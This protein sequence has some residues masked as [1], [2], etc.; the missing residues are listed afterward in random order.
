MQAQRLVGGADT[1]SLPSELTR[2][3]TTIKDLDERSGRAAASASGP[4]ASLVPVHLLQLALDE[5]GLAG[6][7]AGDHQ[8]Q[9]GA[10][11]AEAEPIHTQSR[12][13]RRK[14]GA[15]PAAKA[16]LGCWSVSASFPAGVSAVNVQACCE[17]LREACSTRSRY[18]TLGD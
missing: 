10:L 18:I 4:Q 1:A 7:I 15:Q 17:S 5:F 14:G 6:S 16:G 9:C 3:L 8:A 2:T 13:R 11:P 12:H